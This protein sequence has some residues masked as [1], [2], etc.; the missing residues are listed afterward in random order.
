MPEGGGAGPAE[1][2]D[3]TVP[4]A[5]LL[6]GAA[7]F[8]DFDG[9]LTEVASAPDAVV[10]DAALCDLLAMLLRRHDGR[11]M[12]VSGRSIAQLDD[13]L[14]PIAGSIAI[15]GSHGMERRSGG[16]WDRPE[17]PAAL[18]AAA[19]RLR[20][21]IGVQPGVLVEEKTFGIGLHYRQAPAAAAE[22]HA[23][24]ERLA[25]ELGLALQPGKMMVE[26]RVPGADKGAAVR[27][28]MALP[29]YSGA[30]PV[31]IGDDLTDEPA[32]EAA[33]AL[34]GAGVLVGAPRVT[35]AH[36]RLQSPAAVRRWLGGE[37]P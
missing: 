21:T 35:A 11:V 36:Y 29:D 24:A 1:R 22:A 34:G 26:L 37:A 8:L 28:A 4:P 27:A 25:A 2:I 30:A 14:G 10:V 31:F 13:L 5:E 15:S 6:D 33:G 20:R 9:T 12:L 17:R 3:L 23:L 16:V 7:L 18:D 19:E 32:F